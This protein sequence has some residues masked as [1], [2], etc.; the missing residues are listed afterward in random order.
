MSDSSSD[1]AAPTTSASSRPQGRSWRGRAQLKLVG[2][3]RGAGTLV[4]SGRAIPAAYELDVFSQGETHSV[5]GKLDG[6]FS[7][8]VD[9]EESGGR[10]RLRLDDGREIEID[11][12]DLEPDGADFEVTGA[13][14]HR[15][16]GPLRFEASPA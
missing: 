4:W 2:A 3:Q 16:L 9:G 8:L 11:V 6:D 5:Q 15:A 13:N 12:V 10:A 7:E 14:A 1:R